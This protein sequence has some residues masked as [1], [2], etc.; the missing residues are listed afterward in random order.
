M[1]VIIAARRVFG[2]VENSSLS[3]S[4]YHHLPICYTSTS[5]GGG[6]GAFGLAASAGA[7]SPT[8]T[9]MGTSTY[10]RKSPAPPSFRPVNI[11]QHEDA[12][13]SE[14]G[15]PDLETI[16]LPPAY[17]NLRIGSRPMG[18]SNPS[19]DEGEAAASTEP[20]TRTSNGG[21]DGAT[22]AATSTAPTSGTGTQS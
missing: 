15:Q 1:K 16:E 3:L 9:S 14:A 13:P 12:G 4:L 2:S 17:T 21:A 11:V 22:P 10:F 5:G 8:P 6:L 7:R 18:I 20:P 19:S